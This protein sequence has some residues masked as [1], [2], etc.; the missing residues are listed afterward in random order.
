MKCVCNYEYE[1]EFTR[2]GNHIVLKGSSPFLKGTDLVV[3]EPC[4]SPKLYAIYVCPMCGTLKI[5]V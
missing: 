4:N 1:E 2:E 5:N 3:K